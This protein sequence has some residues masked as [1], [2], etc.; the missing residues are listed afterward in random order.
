MEAQIS[1]CQEALDEST[2]REVEQLEMIM[3]LKEHYDKLE[4][5][6]EEDDEDCEKCEE[7]ETEN[8]M[9]REQVE[10]QSQVIEK[11]SKAQELL[12]LQ[13]KIMELGL[14]KELLSIQNTQKEIKRMQ[15]EAAGGEEEEGE[16]ENEE[17]EE[18]EEKEE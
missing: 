14:N 8:E 1:E 3:T 17:N 12:M 10:Q 4:E 7:H 5:G 11:L 15:G 6:E 2:K 9:L 13:Y 18:K 16:D